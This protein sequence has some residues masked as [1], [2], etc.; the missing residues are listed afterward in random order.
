MPS[1]LEQ[2]FHKDMEEIYDIAKKK[3]KYN[4]GAF[5]RMVS[6]HGGLETAKRLLASNNVQSGFT[7]LF[8]CGRLDL[9]VEAHVIQKK[10]QSLFTPEEIQTARTRLIALNYQFPD[11]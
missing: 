7:E 10:Y 3:Y 11:E 4:A 6:E 2:Q 8:M 1:E 5:N 9:T